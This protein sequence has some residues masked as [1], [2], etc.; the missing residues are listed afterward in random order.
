MKQAI[1]VFQKNPKEGHTKTRLAATIG[2]TNAMIVY[3]ELVRHVHSIVK[4]FSC[5]KF[6]FFS[7]FIEEDIRWADY[8][9]RV[10][11]NDDLGSRMKN[12][13]DE[14]FEEGFESAILVGTDCYHLSEAIIGEALTSLLNSDYCLGPALDGGYYLIG[15][16]KTDDEVFLKKEWSTETVF[17]E[18]QESIQQIQKILHIL[19]M[20]SDVDTEEDLGELRKFLIQ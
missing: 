13:L 7:D 1:I 5:E 9:C 4:L 15:A 19:P 3:T 11:S 17:L 18:A 2:H 20:L 6:I 8:Q 12:A 10:Q 16:K 14:V